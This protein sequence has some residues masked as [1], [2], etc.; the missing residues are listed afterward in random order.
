MPSLK[1]TIR[2]GLR[3]FGYDLQRVSPAHRYPVEFGAAEKKAFDHVRAH[4]LSMVSDERLFA[5]I[6]ACK[7]VIEQGI[8][9]DF[10]ECGVYKGGNAILAKMLF[11]AAGVERRVWLFDTFLGMTKP[12]PV[13]VD[14]GTGEDALR[15]YASMDRGDHNDWVYCPIDQVKS[16]FEAAGL[17]DD[18]V[19]FVQGDVLQTLAQPLL[20][21]QIAV[22]RLDTDWYESTLKELQVLYPRLSVGGA[23]LIDDYGH[24][25]GAQKATDEYF[26]GAV[27]RPLLNYTDYTGRVAVKVGTD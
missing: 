19:V 8:P 22:L 18:K 27:R 5:T 15:H 3:S 10:V 21:E 26:S 14:T 20:P 23:L 7:H 25:Q 17:L 16:H 24:F 12:L 6:L 1:K 13:D 4:N 11:D 9:G 2:S